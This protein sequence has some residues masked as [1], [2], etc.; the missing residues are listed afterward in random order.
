M[1]TPEECAG[2]VFFLCSPLAAAVT[3]Q[4]INANGG[5]WVATGA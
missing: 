2:A 3:G 4:N 5:Q 1:P